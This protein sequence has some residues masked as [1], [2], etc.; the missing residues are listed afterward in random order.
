MRIALYKN[1]WLPKISKKIF[2]REFNSE[3]SPLDHGHDL[4]THII[5]YHIYFSTL[6]DYNRN[7]VYDKRKREKRVFELAKLKLG[8]FFNP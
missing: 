4:Y 5:L 6:V 1:I 2:W 8:T 7:R 3:M